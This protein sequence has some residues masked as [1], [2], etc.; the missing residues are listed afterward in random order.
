[1]N[2]LRAGQRRS[3]GSISRRVTV[4]V[5][6]IKASRPANW[7][8]PP[9]YSM[10]GEGLFPGVKVAGLEDNHSPPSSAKFKNEGSCTSTPAYAFVTCT[11]TIL[12]LLY[13]C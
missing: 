9:S 4:F 13:L 7:T 12:P 1:V 5:S 8:H 2:R 6:S 10:G 11:G 3:R